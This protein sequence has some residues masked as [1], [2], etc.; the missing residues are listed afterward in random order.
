MEIELHPFQTDEKLAK[1]F[2]WTPA[3]G[4]QIYTTCDHMTGGAACCPCGK[5]LSPYV[6]GNHS[7]AEIKKYGISLPYT[8]SPDRLPYG[9]RGLS[10][11][12]ALELVYRTLGSMTE[13]EA[14]NQAWMRKM[15]SGEV[16]ITRLRQ[17]NDNDSTN[18][19][20][21]ETLS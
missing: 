1:N 11:N 18:Q 15:I 16:Y 2:T 9:E 21:R 8:H 12:E 5:H 3:P 19:I 13:P 10:L 20:T 6:K 14:L 17:I 7:D 4:E